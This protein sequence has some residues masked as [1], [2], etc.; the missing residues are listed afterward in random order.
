MRALLLVFVACTSTSPANESACPTSLAEG[1]AC[2]FAGRCWFDNTFSRCL[3]GWCTCE[4]GRVTCDAIA[5]REGDA[6]VDTEITACTYEGTLTCESSPTAESC[7]C[8][9]LGVWHCTCACYGGQ[10]TCSVDPCSRYPQTLSGARCGD[11]GLVCTYPGG[12]TC[13]CEARVS[14]EYPTFNCS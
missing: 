3:S 11:E 14:G 8:D 12:N 4:S 1:D 9:E 10:S 2:S 13:R 7:A 6:C 5:P